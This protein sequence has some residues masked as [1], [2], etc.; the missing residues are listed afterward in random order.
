MNNSNS[1]AATSSKELPRLA[2]AKINGSWKGNGVTAAV[3]AACEIGMLNAGNFKGYEEA[4]DAVE[5]RPTGRREIPFHRARGISNRAC[6]SGHS[7]RTARAV[8]PRCGQ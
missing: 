3:T 6:F 8:Q 1:P 5:R 2:L 4:R 7:G